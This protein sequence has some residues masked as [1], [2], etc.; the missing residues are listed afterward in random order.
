MKAN[1][2]HEPS[3]TWM[4]FLAAMIGLVIAAS[5]SDTARG[6]EVNSS[7]EIAGLQAQT[8][9]LSK[10]VET[11][12]AEVATVEQKW[13]KIASI[14]PPAFHTAAS[15]IQ[16][17]RV[18]TAW[19]KRPSPG[20]G[21]G[22]S[23]VAPLINFELKN[24]GAAPITD[25]NIIVSFYKPDKEVIGGATISI[26]MLD[27]EEGPLRTG[28]WKKVT[29]PCGWVVFPEVRSVIALNADLFLQTDPGSYVLI[30]TYEISPTLEP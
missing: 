12:K 15:A 14:Q 5:S 28:M 30:D 20:G 23:G 13:N 27:I 19:C 18:T 26:G 9:K 7:D 1:L 24:I 21:G 25:I 4:A 11:L 8:D 10:E 6:A 2:Q 29:I 22:S 17:S 3:S 16:I